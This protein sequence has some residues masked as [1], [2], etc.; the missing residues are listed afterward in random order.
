[1]D[2]RRPRRSAIAMAKSA[3]SAP[4]R[5]I[6]SASPIPASEAPKEWLIGLES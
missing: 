4:S 3:N 6:A 5:V 2:R 1:M